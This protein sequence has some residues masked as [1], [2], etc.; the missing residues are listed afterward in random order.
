MERIKQTWV[1][2]PT[3]SKATMQIGDREISMIGTKEDLI[4]IMRL[5]K[6]NIGG[7]ISK[8]IIIH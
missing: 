3:V 1:A 4:Y 7:K 2:S 8:I 6:K 5:I